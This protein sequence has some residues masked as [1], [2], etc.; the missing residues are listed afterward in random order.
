M[1]YAHVFRI[2]VEY[3]F[4]IDILVYSTLDRDYL[5]YDMDK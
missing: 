5:R 4:S 1:H 2:R 3:G